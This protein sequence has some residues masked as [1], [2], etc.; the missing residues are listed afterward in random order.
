MSSR[1]LAALM[2]NTLARSSPSFPKSVEN[3]KAATI[4]ADFYHVINTQCP[5]TKLLL[6]H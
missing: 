6:V 4:P 3:Q 5:Q 2:N 1:H